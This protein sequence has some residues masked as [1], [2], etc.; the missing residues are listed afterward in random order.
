MRKCTNCLCVL[1]IDSFYQ[2]K[3]SDG[4][5]YISG[6]CKVCTRKIQKKDR[7]IKQYTR[8]RR[9]RKLGLT[10]EI[11]DAMLIEQ[12][13]VCKLCKRPP[14]TMKLAVD[15]CHDTGKVRG[16]LCTNCNTAIGVIEKNQGRM[17]EILEYVK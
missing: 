5:E 11:Y 4:K 16:L 1:S 14:R 17:R 7:D 15:H 6:W 2:W 3:K 10:I 13:N 9:Y 8:K 12:D